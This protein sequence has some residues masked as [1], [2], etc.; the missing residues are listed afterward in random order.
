AGA[1]EEAATAGVAA[2]AG[3]CVGAT[4]AATDGTVAADTCVVALVAAT[5]PLATGVAL[6]PAVAL[7]GAGG[8]P[9]GGCTAAAVGTLFAGVVVAPAA[10]LAADA[11]AA[12][13]S[14]A[15]RV[16]LAAP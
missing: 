13:E 15:A 3:R 9:A 14:V 8:V 7:A 6:E 5:G 16:A 4:E 10:E 12:G 11:A 1:L 2:V